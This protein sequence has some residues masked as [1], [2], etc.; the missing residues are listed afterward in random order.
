M[1]DVAC[2]CGCG[3]HFAPVD[4]RG[5]P[6][7]FWTRS[8]VT[9]MRRAETIYMDAGPLVELFVRENVRAELAASG[10]WVNE[11]AVGQMMSRVRR[12]RRVSVVLADRVLVALGLEYWW[13]TEPAFRRVAELPPRG[14]AA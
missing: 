8:C 14:L 10:F 13:W 4:K 9:R 7:K 12:S 11:E 6:R 1:T 3:N 2:P 5:R